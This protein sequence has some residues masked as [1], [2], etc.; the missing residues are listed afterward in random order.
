MLW[1]RRRQSYDGQIALAFFLAYPILRFNL[2]WL[3]GDLSRGYLIEGRL[4]TSQTVSLFL[5]GGATFL[6]CA[7]RLWPFG[8]RPAATAQPAL[9]SS[10]PESE[11]AAPARRAA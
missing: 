2:E 10:P 1:R 8:A 5:F 11:A 6:I 7:R 9:P 3:R 4:S